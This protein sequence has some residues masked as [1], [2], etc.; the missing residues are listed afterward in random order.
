MQDLASRSYARA[1]KERLM[2]KA[3][4][5]TQ[6]KAALRRIEEL[7]WE[8]DLTSKMLVHKSRETHKLMWKL[9]QALALIPERK[10]RIIR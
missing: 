8:L 2:S 4:K 6:H 3:G 5:N 9:N 1:S 10:A 7:E